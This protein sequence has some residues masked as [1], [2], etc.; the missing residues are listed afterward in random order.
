MRTTPH[1]YPT[2][3]VA[4]PRRLVPR[5]PAKV[6]ADI[7]KALRNPPSTLFAAGD[8]IHFEDATGSVHSILIIDIRACGHVDAA[9]YLGRP[10]Y[11]G[12]NLGDLLK[13]R[14]TRIERFSAA[15]LAMYR[16]WL[17]MDDL[18]IERLEV[19]A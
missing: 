3:R 12:T 14:V 17:Q 8:L 15:D 7:L 9:V 1:A 19:A 13:L 16:S 10:Y 5:R 11:L 4:L 2:E 6:V 18:S